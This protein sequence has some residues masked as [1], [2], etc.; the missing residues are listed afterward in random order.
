MAQKMNPKS[1][2][3]DK[4][5]GFVA[6][7]I[8]KPESNGFG[9]RWIAMGQDPAMILAQDKSLGAD[10]FRVF[11]GLIAHIDYENLLVLNQSDLA[12]ELS[13]QRQNVQR[14][15][16]RLIGVGAILEGPKIGVNRSYRFN[17]QFGW[18]GTGKNHVVALDEVRQQ[19]MKTAGITG[20]VTR[21]NPDNGA[22]LDTY[23]IDMFDGISKA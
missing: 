4:K 23:T 11:F 22:E 19:R 1:E 21:T 20:V 3:F 5:N 18:K 13:M 6:C 12:R 2:N 10:D 15:I 9:G 8:P 16:K 7:V 17:P 14:S